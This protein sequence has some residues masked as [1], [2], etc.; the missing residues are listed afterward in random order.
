MSFEVVETLANDL[1]FCMLSSYGYVQGIFPSKLKLVPW[2]SRP[3]DILTQSSKDSSAISFMDHEYAA[4]PADETRHNLVAAK[5]VA[6]APFL[7]TPVMVTNTCSSVLIMEPKLL[8]AYCVF[9]VV[10]E[11]IKVAF[12]QPF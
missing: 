11:N 10:K 6:L 8:R 3:I 4:V 5:P 9:L 12:I 1:L 7:L 2:Y